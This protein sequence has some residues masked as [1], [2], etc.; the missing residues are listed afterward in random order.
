MEDS[1]KRKPW[2]NA[3]CS[4]RKLR[5]GDADISK[6][7]KRFVCT[8]YIFLLLSANNLKCIIKYSLHCILAFPTFENCLSVFDFFFF[9]LVVL[10][11]GPG[12]LP[13][14]HLLSFLVFILR[15]GAAES[16]S[17]LGWA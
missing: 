4:N 5:E 13:E 11:L 14:L 7:Y 12:P 17:Y 16:L 6:N 3:L 8:F 1:H 10:R 2:N 15:Q 9:S